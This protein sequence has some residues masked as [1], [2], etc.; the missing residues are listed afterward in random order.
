M[1]CDDCNEDS[2]IVTTL[3]TPS[4][5]HTFCRGCER[6]QT[7]ALPMVL[8]GPATTRAD[9]APPLQKQPGLSAFDWLVEAVR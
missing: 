5:T 3:V 7:N 1:Y 2:A 6:A 4:G 9:V 8:R